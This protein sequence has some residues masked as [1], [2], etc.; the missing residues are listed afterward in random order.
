MCSDE[1]VKLVAL[2]HHLGEAL[3]RAHRT[4]GEGSGSEL[5]TTHKLRDVVT[6]G[7]ERLQRGRGS[8]VLAVIECVGRADEALRGS[9]E[10]AVIEMQLTHGDSSALRIEVAL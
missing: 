3:A 2:M 7:G 5:E 1:R 8:Q 9:N 6:R 4:V 10:R